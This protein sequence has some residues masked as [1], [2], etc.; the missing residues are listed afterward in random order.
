MKYLILIFI[1]AALITAEATTTEQYSFEII[2][3]SGPETINPSTCQISK[4]SENG[5]YSESVIYEPGNNGCWKVTCIGTGN[6][7]CDFNCANE[8]INPGPQLYPIADG[9]SILSYGMTQIKDS[10]LTG[11]YSSNISNS[12]G[13]FLRSIQWNSSSDKSSINIQINISKVQI[14]F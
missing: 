8:P 7:F 12:Y 3:S 1:F 11:S 10:I 5:I 14:P 2:N 4:G 9:Y 6:I 13:N